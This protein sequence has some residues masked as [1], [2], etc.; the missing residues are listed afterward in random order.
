MFP[1]LCPE[2]FISDAAGAAFEWENGACKNIT[3]PG[4]RGVA[5]IGHVDGK[6]FLVMRME[7]PHVLLTC[8]KNR[9]GKYFGSLSSTLE[10]VGLLL[11]FLSIPEQLRGRH[12]LLEVDNSSV[13]YAWK[14]KH[15][16]NDVELSLLIRC[17][18]VFESF[19]ECKIHVQHIAR[20]SNDMA[21]LVDNLSR[22]ETT[23]GKVKNLLHNVRKVRVHGNL[24]KWLTNPV[25][26]WDLPLKL[27]DD[28]KYCKEC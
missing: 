20:R 7:W 11:P 3:V 5:S 25:V 23:T 9:K 28:I 27:I 17:L 18:I 6:P 10:A 15:A 12:V 8:A 21:I 2:T 26:D 24:G 14:K 1:P 16:K 19:L 4:D 22:K 13:I